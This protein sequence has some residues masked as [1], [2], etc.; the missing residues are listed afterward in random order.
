MTTEDLILYL[1]T[2]FESY[3]Q[4]C[5][6]IETKKGK[7]EPFVFNN[8]Q[9]VL[10]QMIKKDLLEKK[11]IRYNILKARQVGVSTFIQGLAYWFTSLNKHRA[12]I[13]IAQD[14]DAVEN[15]FHKQD[16]FYNN[17][18][19]WC[20]PM[21]RIS[22]KKELHFAN[23][24]RTG[25]SGLESR[26]ITQSAKKKEVG[27]SFTIQFAHLSEFAFWESLGYNPDDRLLA[28]NQAIPED[29][30]TFLFIETTACGD[31]R[32]KELWED[33]DS[34][35]TNIFIS[36][37]ADDNYRIE[38][39]PFDYF[40]LDKSDN[41]PN[42]D[43][44][45]EWQ[46]IKEQLAIWHPELEGQELIHEIYCRLNWRRYTIRH[47]CLKKV[48]KFQQEYPTIP[49]QAFISTGANL[50]DLEILD[51]MLK[52]KTNGFCFKYNDSI[53]DRILT[54]LKSRQT[55]KNIVDEAFELYNFGELEVFE[56][57]K[58]GVKYVIGAD[59]SEGVEGGDFSS[60][61]VLR[62]PQ[63]VEVVTYNKV[64]SPD[65]FSFVLYCLGHLFNNAL[66]GVEDNDR[67][68]FAVIRNLQTK[69][70]YNNLYRR[71]MFDTTEGFKEIDKI[72]WKT[73]GKTKPLMIS[74]LDGVISNKTIK[75]NST[76]TIKQL[77]RFKLFPDG[78]TGV[79]KPNHDDLAIA[80]M[81]SYQMS[82]IVRVK[83]EVSKESKQFTMSD[84]EKLVT[85]QRQV[86]E[87][88]G[89]Y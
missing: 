46:Y 3:S 6:K 14:D 33:K 16:V 30:A 64:V 13:T 25:K 29:P 53:E 75:F 34:I 20:K 31:G 85:S 68:G 48:T 40:D 50:F 73:T 41:A 44:V 23:P 56:A 81:I 35:F 2:D 66:I 72:G 63:L 26:I 10:W 57:P 4:E 24:S 51:K 9:K 28:L 62:L 21:L 8:C 17:S 5:L 43:E 80:A 32:H 82:K 67:G 55:I 11:P 76:E 38:I 19:D 54:F 1:K 61:V 86:T 18:P 52:Y 59:T 83:K 39:D 27:R 22:N 74:D 47:K 70:F 89:L 77:M 69:L 87:Y 78:K 42:G 65:E 37:I 71:Q 45:K 49:E 84:F 88:R 36:W 12:A 79:A 58:E 7:L 15:L 60:A